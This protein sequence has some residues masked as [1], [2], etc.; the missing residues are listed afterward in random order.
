MHVKQ[1]PTR[2][3]RFLLCALLAVWFA[4]DGRAQAFPPPSPGATSCSNPGANWLTCT[5]SG[6]TLTLGAATGQA[7]HQVIG[8]CGSSTAFAPCSLGIADLP[9]TLITSASSLAGNAIMTGAGLQASQTTT[10]RLSGGVFYPT[11]DSTTAIQLDKANA[12]TVVL[13]V[14][15]TN[16]RVGVGTA[17]PT[18]TLTVSGLSTFGSTTTTNNGTAGSAVCGQPIVGGLKMAYCN[19]SGYQET[20]TAQTWTFPTPFN[21]TP[22][23][24]QSGGSCGTYNPSVTATVLTLP[25]NASMTA[26]TC[27]LVI[28]GN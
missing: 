15:T 12:S 26:E 8:T 13:N 21:T 25:A 27:D 2:I 3:A 5:I 23:L 22:V 20:G 24:L 18:S 14:D 16:G 7:P 9:G 17:S 10:T 6:P 28:L 4:R 19:L 1:A 11:A